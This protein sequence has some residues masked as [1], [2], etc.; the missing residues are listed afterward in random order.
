MDINTSL[1]IAFALA[2]LGETLIPGPTLALVFE[3]RL[4][5]TKREIGELIVGITAAN[6]VWVLAAIFI[7]FA[8]TTWLSDVAY[9]VLI[10][11]GA[12]Y[13][14]YLASRRIL[15]SS[16]Q[17]ITGASIESASISKGSRAFATGFMAHFVNPLTVAYYVSTFGVATSGQTIETKIGFGLI[18]IFSDLIAY[19]IIGYITFGNVE[20]F[21][22]RPFF[23]LLAGSALLYF[24]A[25]VYSSTAGSDANITIT[26]LIMAFMLIGFLA[27]AIL[28]AYDHIVSRKGKSNVM[29][30][31]IGK[32]W[33]IWFSIIAV[34]G[35]FYS[36]LSNIHGSG[37]ALGDSLE[38]YFKICIVVAA[39]MALALSFFKAYGEVQD[40]KNLS[41][42]NTAIPADCWHA[43][44]LKAG[45]ASFIFLLAVFFL[46]W[47][48]GFDIR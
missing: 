30:W 37:F 15:G 45:G 5:R 26:P 27:A 35:A 18:A 16:I 4:S 44:P 36:L 31:R 17:F 46:M 21:F 13:L 11:L 7:V 41:D 25:R 43:S 39:V 14:I 3:S 38:V 32:L 33:G 22:K 48:T 40:E 10:H 2:T 29:L 47:L 9:P 23:R 34:F 8:G 42:S 20:S 12:A 28:E 19:L 6:S 24:V 1:I